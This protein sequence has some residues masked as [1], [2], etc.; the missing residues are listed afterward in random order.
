MS[1]RDA[2]H[3]APPAGPIARVLSRSRLLVLFA[4]ATSLVLSA[5]TFAW[6]AVKAWNFTVGL[7]EDRGWDRDVTVVSLLEAIDVILLGTVLLIFAV[8]LYELFVAPIELP[9]W[10]VIDSLNDLKA[11]LSDVIVLLLAI[12]FVEKLLLAK[13]AVDVLYYGV[14][15][16]LVIGALVAFNTLRTTR[17]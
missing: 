8:G 5:V 13:E 12:K 1:D 15:I 2:P 4:V 6:G 10:L 11:K 16:A 17:H 14:G 9:D 3:D 7:F